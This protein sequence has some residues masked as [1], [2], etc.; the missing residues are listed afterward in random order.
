MKY[1]FARDVL[2]V[3]AER[4]CAAKPPNYAEV[5]E[6]DR[7]VREFDLGAPTHGASTASHNVANLG[8][9]ASVDWDNRFPEGISGPSANKA[10]PYEELSKNVLTMHRNHGQYYFST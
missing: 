2:A 1:R 7:L 5:L 6:L 8:F 10:E 3:V 9:G 4:L